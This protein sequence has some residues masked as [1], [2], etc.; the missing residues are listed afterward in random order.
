MIVKE[1]IGAIEFALRGLVFY[2]EN[3]EVL[4]T[5]NYGIIQT[6]RSVPSP[7]PKTYTYE[8]DGTNGIVDL[9]Y[10]L[11]KYITFK[12]ITAVYT[13]EIDGE[14]YYRES[15]VNEIINLLQGRLLYY[16]DSTYPDSYYN[17]RV[18]VSAENKGVYHEIK[19]SINA[20]P[21]R[22]LK[23]IST[24]ILVKEVSGMDVILKS[25]KM[26]VI[27]T[28]RNNGTTITYEVTMDD[29]TVTI[30][31]NETKSSADIVLTQGDNNITVVMTGGNAD[32]ILSLEWQDVAS[33][34]SISDWQGV[35]L[36]EM[37]GKPLTI[38]QGNSWTWNEFQL[39]RWCD[40]RYVNPNSTGIGTLQID[41]ENGKI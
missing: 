17:G 5:D 36:T 39:K 25:G 22:M 41:Y 20:Y 37:Q 4:R 6:A 9:T 1:K 34:K 24:D 21:Y 13:F 31:P 3:S 27:P 15:V 40:L 29:K 33:Q 2:D 10:T 18:T 11:T 12:N 35:A 19:I 16:I 30:P 28:F 38:I 7:E 8:I 23:S 14:Y 32:D 26:P